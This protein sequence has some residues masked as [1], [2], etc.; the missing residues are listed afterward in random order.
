[1]KKKLITT[2]L[3]IL[4]SLGVNS[5][6]LCG[7]PTFLPELSDTAYLRFK[8]QCPMEIEPLTVVVSD[9]QYIMSDWLGQWYDG[10]FYHTALSQA[11]EYIP[12]NLNH[13]SIFTD[14]IV[15]TY[16]D[17]VAQETFS[18]DK[19]EEETVDFLFDVFDLFGRHLGK[20]ERKEIYTLPK[21][22]YIL[23]G[24]KVTIKIAN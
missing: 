5:Q 24:E 3:L 8:S 13:F 2:T 15:C 22:V 17:G 10:D 20:M 7:C 4:M 21:S 9:G 18:V 16:I 11:F 19:F 14:G 1:M 6:S 12:Y 23:K